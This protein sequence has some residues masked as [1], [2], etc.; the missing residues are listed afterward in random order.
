MEMSRWLYFRASVFL[1]I[2]GFVKRM[3][4]G[5]RAILIDGERVLLIKHSYLP[6][7]HFPG[8]GVDQ[9]ETIE[10]GMTREVVEETGYKINGPV[11]FVGHYLNTI[12]PSRDH[13]A[14]FVCRH[15]EV[16]RIFQPNKEIIEMAWFDRHALPED[17][18]KATR[19]RLAEI[20]DGEERSRIWRD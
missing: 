1:T 11:D 6:G 14:V 13:V 10:E 20:F 19:Q 2:L 4:I 5:V 15:F 9:G 7:W 18:S 17:T 3:T 16:E 8:G 12:P